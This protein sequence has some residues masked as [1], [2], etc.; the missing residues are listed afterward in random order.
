MSADSQLRKDALGLVHAVAIGVAGTS[1]SYSIAASMAVL[2][3]AV[4]AL[5]PAS[6]L[7]CGLIMVGITAAFV[8]LNGVFP[9]SGASYA[10]V[11]RVLHRDL[12]FLTG[13]VVLV[14]C[15][16]FMVSA[17]IPASTATLLLVAP[18]VAGSKL[19]VIGV[20][21]CWLIAVSVVVVRGMHLT[22]VVQTVMTA[23]EILVLGGLTISALVRYGPQALDLVSWASFAPAAFTQES[24]AAGAL[25]ALFFFWGW[26]VTL[27]LS[28]ETADSRRTPGLAAAL[29]MLVI[30]AAFM[31]FAVVTLAVLSEAEIRT[32]GANVVFAVAEKL[33][34]RPWSYLAVL[35]VMLS[36]VGTL[37]TNVL[38]FA[39]TLFAQSR[40]GEMHRR[41]SSVHARWG[42]PHLATYLISALG[43]VLLGLSLAFP[44]IDAVLKASINAIGLEIAFYYGLAAFACAWHFR[45]E[46]AGSARILLFAIAWPLAS[47][48]ALWIAAVVA[49]L[50]MDN[51][52][53]LIGIGG[54]LSG[55]IPLA[56]VRIA[57]RTR[58][59]GNAPAPGPG[60]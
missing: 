35:A 29:A 1:L 23:I 48:I 49:A 10:W 30:V 34:P 32:S 56:Y 47:A 33:L 28:E 7:Y 38:Q 43:L 37:E 58:P 16:L 60:N 45:R 9:D 42:T 15:V 27:N 11:G 40:A 50:A 36:C 53:L 20:S 13:W 59:G 2:I 6:L 18:E 22:G 57:E 52:T 55:L 3:G 8:H 17:T 19:H 31:S 5:A 41:W 14:S 54:I 26:D 24:F 51:A 12:G 44:D 46:G 21:A 4:G 39:R 25:I